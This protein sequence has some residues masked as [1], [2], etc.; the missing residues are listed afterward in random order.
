MGIEMS[1]CMCDFCNLVKYKN[2]LIRSK[3]EKY[4]KMDQ[5]KKTNNKTQQVSSQVSSQ[6]SL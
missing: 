4:R 1:K 6:V 3:N 2:N 5:G